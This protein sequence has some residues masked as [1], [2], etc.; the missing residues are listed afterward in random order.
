MVKIK[1]EKNNS[2]NV[3]A[4]SYVR[5]NFVEVDFCTKC[6]CQNAN[7]KCKC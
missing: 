3:I 1:I 4:A 6:K 5:I 7:G 2:G